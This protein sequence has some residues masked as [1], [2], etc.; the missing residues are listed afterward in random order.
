MNS[1]IMDD[2]VIFSK[3]NVLMSK[4]KQNQDIQEL[5]ER[6]GMDVKNSV[7]LTE[8]TSNNIAISIIALLLAKREDD[9]RY[10][11]LTKMGL[12]K[13]SLKTEIIN[14]YKDDAIQLIAKY[15]SSSLK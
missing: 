3:V 12:K 7:K 15:K 1:N 5:A 4:L 11:K 6:N 14:D 9:P 10:R 8:D 13:R 2:D